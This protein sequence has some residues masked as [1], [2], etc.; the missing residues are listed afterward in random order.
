MKSNHKPQKKTPDIV[1]LISKLSLEEMEIVH[2]FVRFY[3]LLQMITEE[4]KKEVL[5]IITKYS[6][7]TQNDT[8]K[9]ESD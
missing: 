7:E 3:K 6:E 9:P 5:A 4:Q 1:S 2:D 8:N